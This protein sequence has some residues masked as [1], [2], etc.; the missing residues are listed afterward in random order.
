MVGWRVKVGLISDV[1]A[2]RPALRAVLH[3]LRGV[4]RVL[5]AGDI[6]GYYTEPNGVIRDLVRRGVECVKGN[7]DAYLEA[8][9]PGAGTV[10]RRSVSYTKSRLTEEHGAFLRALPTMIERSFGGL[11]FHVCHGSPWDHLEEYVYPDFSGFDRFA[12]VDAE[13]I[14]LG[15]THHALHRLVGDK[16]I[17]NPGSCGQPRDGSPGAPY[18]ILDTKTRRVD[19]R[20]ASCDPP[21]PIECI[22]SSSREQ[23]CDP[24][25]S[26]AGLRA[27]GGNR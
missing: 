27:G 3:D 4:D 11:R 23:A 17:V 15:H 1:H 8:L 22:Q 5:C 20:N 7:H 2:N 18:A 26:S 24:K 25:P 13:V 6:T 19:F 14:V 10:L 12:C 21:T 9:P 16:I